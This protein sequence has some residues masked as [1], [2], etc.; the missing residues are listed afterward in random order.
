[1]LKH[2]EL[3]KGSKIILDGQPYEILECAPFKVQ[4]RKAVIQSKIRNLITGNVVDRNFHQSE[5]FEEADL[6]KFDAKFLYVHRDSYFFCDKENPSKRFELGKEQIGSGAKYLK[7]NQ[8]VEALI[9]GE[10]IIGITLPI[11]I[12]LKVT[13]APP[14]VKG[15]RAQ[16]GTKMVTLETGATINTPLFIEEG[17]VIEINTETEQYVKRAE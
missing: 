2:T 1:M 15:E 13:E 8:I 6:K 4:Q 11:K 9:F 5:T 12:Q 16:A 10:K 3:K 7:Q 17:D 14:G